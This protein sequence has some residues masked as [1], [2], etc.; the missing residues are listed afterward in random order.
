MKIA[1]TF[2]IGPATDSADSEGMRARA[3]AHRPRRRGIQRPTH[4]RRLCRRPEPAV[5]ERA[6]HAGA[7]PAAHWSA[8]VGL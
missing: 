4:H 5:S 1:I 7:L 6:N 3:C 8:D 2:W